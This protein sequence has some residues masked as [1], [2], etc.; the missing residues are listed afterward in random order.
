MIEF[1]EQTIAF[2]V[3]AAA[4]I[5]KWIESRQTS[6]ELQQTQDFFDPEGRVDT[7]PANTPRRSYQMSASVR[8]YLMAGHTEQERA[9]LEKQIDAAEASGRIEYTISW[10]GGYYRIQ[11]GQIVG[12]SR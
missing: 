3:A 2:L 10:S 11:Y 1:N 4:A 9:E 8:E 5:W 12:G 7:P 6:A